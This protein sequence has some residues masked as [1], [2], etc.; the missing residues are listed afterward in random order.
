MDALFAYLQRK[1]PIETAAELARLRSYEAV[2][3]QG[4]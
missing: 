4:A 1:M 3:V 2:L